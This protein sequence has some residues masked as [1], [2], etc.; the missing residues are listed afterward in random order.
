MDRQP[1]RAARL[2]LII[3]VAVIGALLTA[4]GSGGSSSPTPTRAAPATQSPAASPTPEFAGSIT[5]LAAS[6]LTEAFNQEAAAFQKAHPGVAV[7]FSFGGSPTLVTQL[8]QG[9]PADVLATAD[10][11]NMKA[12]TDKALVAPATSFVR[13]RL[14]IAVPKSNPAQ[15][16]SPNDLAKPNLKLVLAAKGVPVGDYARQS[17]KN[18]EADAAFGAGF[19]D[20][21]LKNLVSEEPNVKSVVSKIQLGE[22]D[23]GIVYKTDITAGVAGDVSAVEISDSFNVIASYPIAITS[24]A[25]NP[26]LA[27]AFIDFMLSTE[28]QKVLADSG[29]EPVR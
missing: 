5:V 17:L 28:G 3:A 11:K 6:S 24:K 15:I 19:S 29:F 4:C 9:A 10:E 27:A 16:A 13:N 12:A 18:M 23:A 25:G 20:K 7:K 22:A 14:V 8:D 21:V 1:Q 26:A 2:S